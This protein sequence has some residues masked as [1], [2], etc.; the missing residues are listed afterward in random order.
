V[1]VIGAGAAGS[2]IARLLARERGI[3][4]VTCVDRNVRRA[5]AFLKGH[6]RKVRLVK[7]EVR[8]AVD[9]ERL[10]RGSTVVVNAGLPTLNRVILAG[11]LRLGAH[12]QDLCSHLADLKNAEQLRYDGQFRRAGLRALFNTGVAPGLTNLLAADL[13][14]R[15]DEVDDILFRLIEDQDSTRPIFTWSPTVLFDELV[16]PPLVYRKRRFRLVEPFSDPEQYPFPAPFGSR[17]V[18]TIYGDEIA[19]IPRYLR[20]RRADM[21]SGGAD[22]DF[23]AALYHAGVLSTRRV[24]FRGRRL[25]PFDFFARLAGVVPT[26]DVTLALVRSGA[27]RNAHLV[28]AVEVTGKARGR[29]RRGRIAAVYPDLKAILRRSPGATYISWP[30]AISAVAFTRA[31]LRHDEPGAIPPEALPATLRARVRRDLERQGVSFEETL[32]DLRRPR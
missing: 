12:Y 22:I 1:L 18:F 26:P 15:F 20:C 28:V 2:V 24:T 21:K 23:G 9:V 31:L 27:I 11:A 10:G 19:T 13:A 32:S 17:Q 8:A 4:A 25:V 16:A 5:R 7:G 6:G 3:A 14:S 30:T 29:R